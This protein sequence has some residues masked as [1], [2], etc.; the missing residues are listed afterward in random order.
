M[1][2]YRIVD[3]DNHYYEPDDC[4]TRHLEARYRSGRSI[5]VRRDRADGLGRVYVGEQRATFIKST[6]AD[7]TGEPGSFQDYLRGKVSRGSLI[8]E[9]ISAFD[10][11]AYMHREPRLALMDGQNVEA[12][13]MLPTLGVCVECDMR[14]DGEALY[15]NFRSFNR[16][17]EEDW[18]YGADGRIIGVPM[19]TLLNVTEAVRE[20]KRVIEAGA[21]MVFLRPGPVYGRSPAD[22]EFDP[23]W[24]LC[25]EAGVVVTI[26]TGQTGLTEFYSTVWGEQADPPAMFYSPFQNVICSPQRAAHDT[27]AAFV[28][29][30]LFNR[31]SNLKVASIENGS[32]WVPNLLYEM[33][34]AAG[35]NRAEWDAGMPSDLV[36]KHVWIAPYHEDDPYP[37]I[38]AIGADRVIFGSDFPHPEGL[39]EPSDY[40]ADIA[41]LAANDIRRIMR[42][43]TRELLG[44][45]ETATSTP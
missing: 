32:S 37:L 42:D 40:L 18:G 13:V 36:R 28:L 7:V 19:M 12:A 35:R 4:F 24:A 8:D 6:H 41:D 9:P 20:L 34:K 39:A 26:H 21:R 2:D 25:D 38:K 44:L 16:W 31:H 43:N 3:V 22:K 45:R 29:H 23:F 17:V 27:L 1:L 14:E 15:A 30:G 5:H 10:R 11:P 33:D